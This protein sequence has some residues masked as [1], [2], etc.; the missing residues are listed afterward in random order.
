MVALVEGVEERGRPKLRVNDIFR[1]HGEAFGVD[2][3]LTPTQHKVRRALM[4][5]RTAALG[6]HLEVCDACGFERPAYNSCRNRHCPGCQAAA[7][8]EWLEQRLAR[9]LPTHHFHVVF[10]L[11]EELRPLALRNG[12]VVYDILLRAAAEALDVLGRQRLGARLGVT[13]VLHTWTRA[14]LFHPHVHCVVTGGGLALD[15]SKWVPTPR[16]FLLPVAV[17][18]KLFRGMVRRQLRLS[19]DAGKLDLGGECAALAEPK[20]FARLLRSLFRKRW[21][22]YSKP[23]FAGADRVFEYLGRYTHRV[24]ISDH[25]LLALTDDAVTMRTK[26]GQQATIAPAEFIRRFLLHVLPG[27]FHKIRHTGLYAGATAGQ[28]VRASVVHTLGAASNGRCLGRVCAG[29]AGALFSYLQHCFPCLVR[30]PQTIP[31]A[32]TPGKRDRPGC[33]PPVLSP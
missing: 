11:P 21:V 30:P 33:I 16:G 1:R 22:V 5:C 32:S 14:M 26:H 19:Y 20:V 8:K 25:R 23:P 12:A 9:V 15:G 27:G 17:L 29:C 18:R 13:S 4:L 2:H 7:S 31:I 10:T 24:A 28:L 3:V 6:G